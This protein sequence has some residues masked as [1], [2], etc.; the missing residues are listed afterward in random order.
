MIFKQ[1]YIKTKN[2]EIVV[3]SETLKHSDFKYLKPVSAGFVYF[4]TIKGFVDCEVYG[5]SVSLKLQPESDDRY[6]IL[7]QIVGH[8]PYQIDELN[9]LISHGV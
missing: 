6:L 2:K 8:T 7:R 3:F 9:I 4:T 1:K 5:G